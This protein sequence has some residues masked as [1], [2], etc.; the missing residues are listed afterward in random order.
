MYVIKARPHGCVR[1]AL[2]WCYW[3]ALPASPVTFAFHCHFAHTPAFSL[4]NGPLNRIVPWCMSE[5]LTRNI[6]ENV[7]GI[8]GACATI[9]SDKRPM[10]KF[11]LTWMFIINKL[12]MYGT[13]QYAI[14][15]LIKN[16]RAGKCLVK[17]ACK[18]LLG[19]GRPQKLELPITQFRNFTR[20][21]WWFS[22]RLR[23]LQCVSRLH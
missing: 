1:N 21:Y 5:S 2:D 20:L 3:I 13:L 11:A 14:R 16:L 9:I 22:A 7:P 6:R 23:Y 17:I 8:P 18:A 12:K 19:V 15:R 10:D 4:Y